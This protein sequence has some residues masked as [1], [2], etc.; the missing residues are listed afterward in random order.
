MS[1]AQAIHWRSAIEKIGAEP[2]PTYRLRSG[3]RPSCSSR[4]RSSSQRAA[5]SRLASSNMRMKST[6][7]RAAAGTVASMI[8]R[9]KGLNGGRAGMVT[10]RS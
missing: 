1:S 5:G 10:R 4:R 6:T 8:F 3:G 2:M 9:T 7:R